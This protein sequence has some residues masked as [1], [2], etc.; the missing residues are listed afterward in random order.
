[1]DLLTIEI[2]WVKNNS[3]IT[4]NY[5]EITPNKII[6]NDTEVGEIW[7]ANITVG[8]GES[9]VNFTTDSV[10]IFPDPII[11]SN[12]EI[13]DFTTVAYVQSITYG[14]LTMA[15]FML[16]QFLLSVKATR[17]EK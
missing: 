9:S 5:S 17:E 8:D 4:T 13:E 1:N 10:T 7:Y 11:E 15:T 3:T 12:E 2:E 6:S 14:V 16:L